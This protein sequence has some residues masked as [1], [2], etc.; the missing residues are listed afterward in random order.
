M[1][2]QGRRILVVEDEPL[3]S[4]LIQEALEREDFHVSVAPDVI[5]AKKLLRTVDPDLVLL[6]ISL[7]TGPPGTQLAYYIDKK[8]PGVAILFLTRH[9]DI[10]TAGIDPELIPTDSGFL[11]KDLVADSSYLIESIEKVLANKADQVRHSFAD[12][13]PLAA[14]TTTQLDVLKLVAQGLSNQAIATRRDITVRSVEKNLHSIFKALQ[15]DS[16]DDHNLRVRA[17]MVYA[18]HA[19]VP[20]NSVGKKQ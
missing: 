14:L 10:R 16:D 2:A 20:A 17:A 4:S 7:G 15:L 8:H 1:S 5:K 12:G 18:A 13:S 19:G 9:P 11:R 6:D 3:F